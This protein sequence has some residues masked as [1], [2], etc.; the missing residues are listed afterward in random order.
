MLRAAGFEVAVVPRQIDL[1]VAENLSAQ[2]KGVSAV[3]A[4][5]EPYTRTVVESAAQLRVISRTGVGF[6][7]IDLAACD[8]RQVVVATTPGVNHHAVAEHTMA[9]V[10]GVARGFPETD[11]RVRE[12]RWKRVMRPRVMGSTL[13][14]VGFGRIGRAVALR[15]VGV[16]MKVLA[17]DPFPH[18]ELAETL[19]VELT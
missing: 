17:Y 5:S 8:E 1:S 14:I 12:G 11:R 4:G 7:A 15:A 2:L 13:G 3:I 19:R 18:G 9:L 6:D 16:G 10:F